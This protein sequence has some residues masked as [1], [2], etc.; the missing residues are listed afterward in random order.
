[1]KFDQEK[2][3]KILETKTQDLQKTDVIPAPLIELVTKAHKLQIQ[4]R[5]TA[6]AP[7]PDAAKLTGPEQR[8]QGAPILPREDMPYDE[9]QT[10]D[11]FFQFLDLLE[12]QQS[13][14]KDAA[15]V[16]RESVEKDPALIEQGVAA[17]QKGE[18]D[19]FN[20]WAEKTPLAPKTFAFLIDASISPSLAAA[21]EEL[22]KDIPEE[23]VWEFGHCPVC[24]SLPY[25]A[26]LRSKEGYR[27]MHCSYCATDYRTSRLGCPYCDEKDHKK[28]PFTFVE[29]EPGFKAHL[30]D[31]CN[32]YIKTLDYRTMDK[33]VLPLLD[34][35]ASLP[36]DMVVAKKG[37]KRPTPSGLGF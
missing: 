24:G 35:L 11:L 3:L 1:M 6:A 26:E 29:D 10:K 13:P 37:Y 27:Y 23:Q 8:A 20:E 2:L 36:L 25:L 5:A 19:I 15:A 34:D 28:L 31:T 32:M 18:Q 33:M 21:A 22:A 17:Y 9:K 16:I 7:A 30:C 14:M 12:E 4:A